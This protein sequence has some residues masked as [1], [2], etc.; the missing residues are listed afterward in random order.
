MKKFIEGSHAIAETVKSCKPGVI[1]AYPITPQT[2]IVEDLAK[3]VADGELNSQF[4]NVESEH[5]A[6]SCV[7]GGSAAGNRVY[8]ATSSQGLLLMAEVLFNIAGMRLPVVLTCANR[9]VSGPISIWNDQQDSMAV[10]DAGWIMMYAENNQETVDLHLQAFK[11]AEDNNVMLPV[12]ICFDGF[13]L[14]HGFEVVDMPEEEKIKKFLPDYKAP[15]KLDVNDPVSMGLLADPEFYMETRVAIQ[16]TQKEALSLIPKVSAD[17]KNIFGRV[18]GGLIEAYKCEDAD[19]IVIGMGSV[20][21]TIKAQVD[22]LRV[23]GKKAGALKI[24]THR[25]FPK[26]AIYNALKGAKEIGVCEKAISLGNGG[27]LF[28]EIRSVFQGKEEKP[29]ISGFI[30]GLGGRDINM[31]SMKQVFDKLS[32]PQVDCEFIDVKKELLSDKPVVG[33]GGN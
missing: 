5:S 24:I 29:K 25:P 14:T 13:I 1:S 11:I 16:E 21:G 31:N 32:G 23:Q 27:I 19:I 15:Y 8:T 18:S 33:I 28:D 6:A 20:V 9:A 26:E 12:M 2:H 30:I 7:L 22:E 17:F 4:I 3:F 10:R